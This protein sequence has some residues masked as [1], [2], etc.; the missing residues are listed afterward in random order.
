MIEDSFPGSK[1]KFVC[2]CPLYHW[3]SLNQAYWPKMKQLGMIPE[4]GPKRIKK[5]LKINRNIGV[6][7]KDY[8]FY[9]ATWISRVFFNKI[10]NEYR[11]E[12]NR[13]VNHW[14]ENK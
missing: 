1:V 11:D 13:H 4:S 9:V 7:V 5:L 3:M 8:P 6:E 10:K 12:V 2:N 14:N